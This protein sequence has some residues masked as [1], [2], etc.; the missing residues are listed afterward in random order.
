MPDFSKEN[1]KQQYNDRKPFGKQDAKQAANQAADQATN[2]ARQPD[3]TVSTGE[4]ATAGANHLQQ[5]ASANVDEDTKN[6]AREYR[7]RT[8]GYLKDKIPQ[9]RRDQTIWRLKKMIAE[10]QGHQDCEYSSS[11][12]VTN[13][14]TDN[15][16]TSKPL[17][18]C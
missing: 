14:I 13:R 18:L 3:G 11:C 10:I 15:D 17:T 8:S 7:D 2:A 1:L 12:Y 5:Q 4:G 16:Q 6:T 9:E